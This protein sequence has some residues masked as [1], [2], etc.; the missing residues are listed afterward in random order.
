MLKPAGP[1]RAVLAELPIKKNINNNIDT[2]A[3]IQLSWQTSGPT[4]T[5]P[6]PVSLSLFTSTLNKQGI[7]NKHH[8]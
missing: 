3:I 1:S 2:C 4:G 6:P 8:K 5:N 7:N